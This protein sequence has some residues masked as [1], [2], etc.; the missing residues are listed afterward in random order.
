MK[1]PERTIM[2]QYAASPAITSLINTFNDAVSPEYFTEAFLE[3][4]WNIQTADT[5]GLDV[6]GKIVGVSR[7]LTVNDDFLHLGFGEA[8]LEVHTVTDPQPFGQAPFY[9]GEVMTETIELSD[10]VYRKLIMM[11]AMSNITDCTIP[12]INRMLVFMFGE[13]GRAYVTSDGPLKMSYVFEFPLSISELAIIQSSGAL[14]S[15][16]GVSVSIVQKD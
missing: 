1:N 3:K 10:P 5:Y 12:D 6:W 8:M 15:P 4:I 11:K 14:P 2:T 9:S 7:R 13:S 16:P